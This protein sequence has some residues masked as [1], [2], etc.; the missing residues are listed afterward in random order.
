MKKSSSTRAKRAEPENPEPCTVVKQPEKRELPDRE[1]QIPKTSLYFSNPVTYSPWEQSEI[2]IVRRQSGVYLLNEGPN[3]YIGQS[4]HIP[5][6]FSSHLLNNSA[7][8]MGDPRC[9]VL[10]EVPYR[11]DLSIKENGELLRNAEDRFIS[12]ALSMDLPLTNSLRGE[13]KNKIRFRHPIISIEL[14][15]LG[16]AVNLLRSKDVAA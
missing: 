8:K 14:E 12:A 2:H 4:V 3:F 13:T 6:R 10:A 9:I 11:A 16:K 1:Q 7:C 5:G 15:R